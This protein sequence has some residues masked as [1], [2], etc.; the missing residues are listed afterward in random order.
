MSSEQ[1]SMYDGKLKQIQSIFSFGTEVDGIAVE[2]VKGKKIETE[3]EGSDQEMK[4]LHDSS[5]NKAA[6]MAAG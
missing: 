3:T 6:D 4:T 5:V 1:K 2:S